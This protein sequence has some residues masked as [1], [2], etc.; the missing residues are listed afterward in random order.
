[1][2]TYFWIVDLSDIK[3][4]LCSVLFDYILLKSGSITGSYYILFR[5]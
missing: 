1:M 2:Q 5:E 3:V 4:T